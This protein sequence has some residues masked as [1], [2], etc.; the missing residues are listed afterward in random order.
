MYT[1]KT[2]GGQ[3]VFEGLEPRK[4]M[5]TVAPTPVGP[6]LIGEQVMGTLPTNV[7]GIVLKFA[8]QL[9]PTTAENVKA[10]RIYNIDFTE[11][12]DGYGIFNIG[13]SDS[14][15]S[16][17][18]IPLASATYD[19]AAL[20]V[21]LTPVHALPSGGQFRWVKIKQTGTDVVLDANGLKAKKDVA[22]HFKRVATKHLRFLDPDGDRVKM[23]LKGPGQIVA[24]L[25]TGSK[26]RQ[27]IVY[28][29]HTDPV[30]STLTTTVIKAKNG[31]GIAHLQQFN[32]NGL[33]NQNLTMNALFSIQTINA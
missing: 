10:Y 19:P 16:H 2:S 5:T 3:V 22:V 21:T 32:A 28:M 4:L 30:L 11:A 18:V 24:F 17:N 31:D 6:Q 7:T 13:G 25:R 8:T 33:I 23:D 14:S 1:K 26:D 9:D 12:V 27:P 20:T 29:L 15:T